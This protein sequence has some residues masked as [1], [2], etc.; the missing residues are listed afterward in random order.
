M[1]FL[2][3]SSIVESF[4]V[5]CIVVTGP[6]TPVDTKKGRRSLPKTLEKTSKSTRQ[7]PTV[8]SNTLQI[9]AKESSPVNGID[10]TLESSDSTHCNLRADK[11][12]ETVHNSDF[13]GQS[14]DE[15]MLKL[16]TNDQGSIKSTPASKIDSVPTSDSV[17][18]SDTVLTSAVDTEQPLTPDSAMESMMGDESLFLTPSSQP[19]QTRWVPYY[20]A[21]Y[22]Q[23]MTHVLNSPIDVLYFSQE[24]Y[25]SIV[26]FNCCPGMN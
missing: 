5:L 14:S 19:D 20:L 4:P 10:G 23:A 15:N 26:T 1:N 18:A 8:E 16:P 9:A 3:L 22:K 6:S 24:D 2:S 17:P 21:N 11:T 12:K 25:S 7:S 13:T